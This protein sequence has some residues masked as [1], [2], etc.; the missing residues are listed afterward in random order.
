[1]EVIC[2][3]YIYIMS[4]KVVKYMCTYMFIGVFI[5]A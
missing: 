1:M 5:R 2:N 4:F 3:I